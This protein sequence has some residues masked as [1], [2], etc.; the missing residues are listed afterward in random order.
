LILRLVPPNISRIIFQYYIK[1]LVIFSLKPRRKFHYIAEKKE[2]E[3][4]DVLICGGGP[5]GL[6]IGYCL[7][8]YGLSTYIVEQHDREKQ[9]M[10]GRAAMIAPRSL[11]MLEQL[12][13]VDDLLQTGFVVRGQVQYKDG[14]RIDMTTYASSNISDTFHD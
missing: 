3:P 12:D 6:L 7:A 1:K 11:E 8:R 10:Y 2:M 14:A 9:I 13:L 4:V 5:V